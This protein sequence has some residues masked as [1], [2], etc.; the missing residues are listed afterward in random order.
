MR[1]LN[2][3]VFDFIFLFRMVGNCL[4]VE[5]VLFSIFEIKYYGNF[6]CIK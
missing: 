1:K 4:F 3:I 2:R 6:N 5:L